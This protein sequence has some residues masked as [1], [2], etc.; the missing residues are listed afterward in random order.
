[1]KKSMVK[2]I[3]DIVMVIAFVLLYKKMLFG[4]AFH[5]IAGICVCLLFIVHKLLNW[6]WIIA[7]SKNL[8]NKKTPRKVR[9]QYIVDVL[10]FIDMTALLVTGIGINKTISSTLAFLPKSASVWHY[11]T[12][13]LALIL[14]GVHVGLHWGMIKNKLKSCFKNVVA[15]KIV[16]S[17]LICGL[18][19]YGVYSA[20]G[21]NLKNWLSRPFVSV[22]MPSGDFKNFEQ[23]RNDSFGNNA[24]TSNSDNHEEGSGKGQGQGKGLGKGQGNGN[25][26]FGGPGGHGMPA[27]QSGNSFVNALKT[28]ATFF[29][30]VVLFGG[31]EALVEKFIVT[32]ARKKK[33]N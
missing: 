16:C 21:S 2:I 30:I 25:G 1:M 20:Y 8:F 18:M 7:V 9:V 4:L 33:N 17:I 3:L 14:I 28:F 29:S 24:E 31:L 13:G 22:N 5:E 19:G 15:F 12:A 32:L 6:N 11:F 10:L 27:A 26:Q 23:S